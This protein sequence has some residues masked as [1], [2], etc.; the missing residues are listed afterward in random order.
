MVGIRYAFARAVRTIGLAG[1]SRAWL[2]GW[3][4]FWMGDSRGSWEG[5]TLVVSRLLT[6]HGTLSELD[7]GAHGNPDRAS[8]DRVDGD[9]CADANRGH[10]QRV[11]QTIPSTRLLFQI[12]DD[13]RDGTK[14]RGTD[15]CANDGAVL[16]RVPR[17][18]GLRRL[19][20]A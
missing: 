17:R 7:P 4:D 13:R 9:S 10:A 6:K 1:K 18:P 19:S 3:P 2:E 12:A 14:C 20:R 8:H 5:D 15:N 11:G 16:E